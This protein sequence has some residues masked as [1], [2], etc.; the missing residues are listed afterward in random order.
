[1]NIFQY[2]TNCILLIFFEKI[3]KGEKRIVLL[4]FKKR[5][6]LQQK[7]MVDGRSK[8]YAAENNHPNEPDCEIDD[9]EA[10]MNFITHGGREDFAKL[11]TCRIKRPYFVKLE[12]RFKKYILRR[13][14]KR[15]TVQRNIKKPC[16]N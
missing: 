16:L 9:D 4:T 11:Y 8:Y 14:Y 1:M 13:G 3:P 7:F 15:K 10:M 5:A 2:I 6:K 12:Q